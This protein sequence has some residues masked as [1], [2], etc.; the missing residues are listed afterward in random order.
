MAHAAT[1]PLRPPLKTIRPG[2]R[3]P[4]GWTQGQ[5]KKGWH[6]G[7]YGWWWRSR[8]RWYFYL[9]PFEPYPP[10]YGSGPIPLTDTPAPDFFA[11]PLSGTPSLSRWYCLSPPGFYPFVTSC[12]GGWTEVVGPPTP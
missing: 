1:Q 9:T 3:A 2:L 8:N 5:W 10:Y 7:R 6:H 11:V 4:R 12:S